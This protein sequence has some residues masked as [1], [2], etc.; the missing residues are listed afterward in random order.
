[1]SLQ[2]RVTGSDGTEKAVLDGLSSEEEYEF[3]KID[4]A[5][6][7]ALR[8]DVN[9]VD[10]VEDEDEITLEHNGETLFG[11]ILRDITRGGGTTELL[12]ES[13]ERLALDA[14]PTPGGET[15]DGAA[16]TTIIQDA[17]DSVPELTAGTIENLDSDLTFVFSHTSPAKKIRTVANATGADVVYNADKTVDVVADSGTDKTATTLS[18][19]NQRV[20]GDFKPEWKAGDDR[21]THL[22]MLGA[23]EGDAQVEAVAVAPSWSTG[24]RKKWDTRTNK[25]Y[26]NAS[27]LG[28]VAQR[29]VDELAA[30]W[31]EVETTVRGVTVNLADRF[32]I[33]HAEEEVDHDLTAVDVTRVI[34]SNGVTYE[35]AFS[36]R[37]E[38]RE[39]R[40]EKD[41]RDVDRYN[42]AF[43]GSPVTIN[44]GGGRQP[45]NS[46]YN[47][48]F[49]VYYPDEVV[50]EHRVKLQ[51]KGMAY[52]AYSQGAA[53][54]GDHTHTVDVTHPEH[55][56]DVNI[57]VATS[58]ANSPHGT[59]LDQAA[60][61]QSLTSSGTWETL[62]TVSTTNNAEVFTFSV[63][64]ENSE[65]LS[66]I[67]FRLYDVDNG[68][69]YPGS[70]GVL[71]ARGATSISD[72]TADYTGSQTITVPAE[73]N[74]WEIQYENNASVDN[75]A[76]YLYQVWGT[77]SHDVDIG[78]E[79]SKTALGSTQ[80]ESS[81]ASGPHSHEPDPGIIES[82][83]GTTHYPSGCDVLVNGTSVGVSLGDGTGPFEATVD[84]AGELIPGQWNTIEI[85]SNSLGHLMAHL[86]IDVYRQ[87]LGRG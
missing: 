31:I 79:T 65:T 8:E 21:V 74:D 12:V 4:I 73:S 71:V 83:G 40:E 45:V 85:A 80:S 38:A 25:D 42:M 54:G 70:G 59:L 87:I 39:T 75:V 81:N 6:L 29:I 67:Y 48:E 7:Y 60:D 24:D 37:V 18:P 19:D 72:G 50:Y 52:R 43:E 77:H 26:T 10:L 27:T 69:Y 9:A 11:G 63:T 34:D 32:H 20:T 13:Y 16:D 17:L 14:E 58:N 82:F 61:V 47:Y 3:D 68:T 55:A 2:Y 33:Y 30:E 64:A 15:W 23:G 35:T 41:I 51:I 44:T 22:R 66:T 57:G 78:T 56:H 86:D 1:M 62:E 5:K 49:D 28:K 36:S 84:I 53:S 76:N 46:S